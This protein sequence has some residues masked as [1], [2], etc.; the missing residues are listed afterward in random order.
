MKQE[1]V[2]IIIQNQHATNRKLDEII[3]LLSKGNHQVKEE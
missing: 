2:I 1:D 3:K